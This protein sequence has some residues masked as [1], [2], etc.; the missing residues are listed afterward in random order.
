MLAMHKRIKMQL[1][2][3]SSQAWNWQQSLKIVTK[4]LSRK[5]LQAVTHFTIEWSRSKSKQ[6]FFE[7]TQSST[8]NM[9]QFSSQGQNLRRQG[10]RVQSNSATIKITALIWQ[11]SKVYISRN[12][13]RGIHRDPVFSRSSCNAFQFIMPLPVFLLTSPLG[14][15]SGQGNTSQW[16]LSSK[17]GVCNTS[18]LLFFLHAL[19]VFSLS[20]N[21]S[22]AS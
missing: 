3:Q 2:I 13:L 18:G 15:N 1:Q 17:I 20:C 10:G 8:G 11:C 16:S 4:L 22:L 9:V 19:L 21:V 6:L 14:E 7:H 12:S 5:K